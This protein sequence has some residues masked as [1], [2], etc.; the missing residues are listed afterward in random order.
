MSD[1]IVIRPAIERSEQVLEELSESTNIMSDIL[2]NDIAG[3]SLVMWNM[4]GEPVTHVSAAHG[5]VALPFVPVFVHDTLNRYVTY[6]TIMVD[7]PDEE[8]PTG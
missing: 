4:R 8:G 5:M 3:F 1:P 2:D 7:L 6:G